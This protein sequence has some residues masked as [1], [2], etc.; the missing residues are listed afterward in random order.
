MFRRHAYDLI[1]Q[2]AID[3]IGGLWQLDKDLGSSAGIGQESQKTSTIPS[4]SGWSPRVVVAVLVLGTVPGQGRA[5]VGL[6]ASVEVG[7]ELDTNATRLQ[8]L[9]YE[10]AEGEFCGEDGYCSSS[11][12]RRCIA[13]DPITAGLL[14]IAANGRLIYKPTD[15][16]ALSLDVNL[17]AKTFFSGDA[18][19]ADEL[20]QRID[21]GWALTIPNA[22]LFSLIGTYYE[23]FQRESLRDL[24]TGSATLGALVGSRGSR[25]TGHLHLGYRGLQY[26]PLPEY[27]FHGLQG[28][29][30]LRARTTSG[31][32]EDPVDWTLSGTYV[33]AYRRFDGR[34][35]GLKPRGGLV[36][37]E[38]AAHR[39][40]LNHMLRAEVAYLGNADVAIWY[41]L[42]I[43]QSNSYGWGYARHI[44][45]IRFTTRL[46]WEV[47]LTVKGV[48]QFSQFND[49]LT[50]N[51][52]SPEEIDSENRSRLAIQLSRELSQRWS[53]VLRNG[54]YLNESS[55][56]ARRVQGQAYLQPYFRLTLFA[57]VRFEY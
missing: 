5:E 47:F 45:G 23:S 7:G 57:G 24:R 39:E 28:G 46:V 30:E 17:G 31:D 25:I 56:K 15:R 40:D 48:L 38:L 18:R 37:P 32:E 50:I 1:Q 44:V 10:C 2:T 12:E 52:Q 16:Q 55:D 35:I 3:W 51:L 19:S 8:S 26:K 43:N 33:A 34:P 49:P 21:A 6:N 29:V 11:P 9:V 13:D 53:V 4:V 36:T 27:N 14:R 54:I 22:G 41:G 20:V 42:E